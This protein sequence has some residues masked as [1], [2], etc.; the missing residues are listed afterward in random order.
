MFT[1]KISILTIPRAN[2]WIF[3]SGVLEMIY[4]LV[5]DYENRSNSRYSDN[6]ANSVNSAE[7][8]G[9]E[10]DDDDDDEGE[11]GELFFHLAF[12]TDEV[13]LMS[14]SKM[15]RKYLHKAIAL[16][17]E[18]ILLTEE[19]FM[20]QVIS[21]GLN[22]GKKILELTQPL[23]KNKISL[24]FISNYF[25][26]LVLVPLKDKAKVEEVLER[27]GEEAVEEDEY[28]G[29]GDNDERGFGMFREK[30]IVPK[31]DTSVQL[32]LTGARSGDS[33]E[34]L[35]QTA[36]SLARLNTERFRRDAPAAFPQYF[37]LTRIPTGETSL[38]LPHDTAEVAKL[39]FSRGKM[40][41]SLQDAYHPLALD[42]SGLPLDLTGIVAGV[43]RTLLQLGVHEM[44]YLSLGRSGFVLVPDTFCERVQLHL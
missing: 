17:K 9:E 26:D 34:I 19:F 36:E 10:E 42:L 20:I 3:K 44:S 23:S 27:S 22:I 13:T 1:S 14:S 8:E 7:E 31:L 18:S 15:I 41:G 4:K 40:M 24:F 29:D 12:T 28:D 21:D 32:V 35:R 37:A 30:Q 2:F 38:L 25:S 6:D 33:A 39:R 16:D 11:V 43:A 5:D